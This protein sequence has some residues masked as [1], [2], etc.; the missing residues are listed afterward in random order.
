MEIQVA[1]SSDVDAVVSLVAKVS[2]IDV[3]PLFNGQGQKEYKKHVLPDLAS[4]LDDDRYV[5]IKAISNGKLLGFAALRDG[6]YLMYLFVD[7]S[8]QGMGLGHQLLTF[9]LNATDAKEIHLRSS[10]NA[11]GFYRHNGFKVLGEETEFNGIRFVPMSL[12]RT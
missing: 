4:A 11:I 5:T 2:D 7:K 3:L 8:A 12:V 1:R 10:I 6:N 9:L